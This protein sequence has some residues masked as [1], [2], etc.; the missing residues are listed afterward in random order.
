MAI[1]FEINDRYKR[2]AKLSQDALN[3]TPMHGQFAGTLLDESNKNGAC[4]RSAQNISIPTTSG[5]SVSEASLETDHIQ[6]T[7][8]TLGMDAR[9]D[10]E[11]LASGKPAHKVFVFFTYIIAL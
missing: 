4:S 3:K 10:E 8:M 5:P 6:S 2:K 7:F 11:R 1:L 9:T